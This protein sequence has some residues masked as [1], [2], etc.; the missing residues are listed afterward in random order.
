M[1]LWILGLPTPV[2]LAAIAVLGYVLGRSSLRGMLGDA[3][4]HP[5]LKRARTVLRDLELIAR[6]IRRD[7][8][9]HHASL[10]RF[11]GQVDELAGSP[12]PAN[13][14]ALADEAE[15]LLGPTQELATQMARAYE[16]LR[17]QASHLA[18][19][20]STQT[21][22]LTGVGTR[23]S[24]DEALA[25]LL[26]MRQRY[27]SVFSLAIFDI[28]HLQELNATQGRLHGDQVLQRVASLLDHNVRETDLVG[29]LGGEEFAVLLPGT[30]LLAAGVFSERIRSAIPQLLHVTVSVG[31]ATVLAKDDAQTLLARA[32][33]ALLAAKTAGRNASYQHDGDSARPCRRPSSVDSPADP[34]QPAEIVSLRSS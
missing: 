27:G 17:Q 19:F 31:V 4:P 20:T 33:A 28:D 14:L 1:D 22:T 15:R 5:E 18:T 29:R 3:S 9:Q 6:H 12:S 24:L 34:A 21:D 11:K 8:G 16:G 7:L 30:D 32:D 13:W 26:E 25:E 2:G 10:V 23:Q